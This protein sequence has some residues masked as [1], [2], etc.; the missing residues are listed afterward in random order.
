MLSKENYDKLDENVLYK[1][2]PDPNKNYL[3][4]THWCRNWTFEVKKI[5]DDRAFM[6]DTYWSSSDDYIKV[7]D[8]N[9]SSFEV[10]FDFR[11][12]EKIPFESHNEYNEK[13]LIWAVTGSGG[14]TSREHYWIRKGTKKSMVLQIE[15]KK[16]EIKRLKSK[17]EWANREL[18]ELEEGV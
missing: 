11:D 2:E 6:Y 9:I 7:T 10:I 3:G 17:L 16:E 4:G 15:K 5:H 14:M 12:V 13:D 1:K 18:K 8:E